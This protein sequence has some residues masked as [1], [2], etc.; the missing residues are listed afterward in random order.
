MDAALKL[1]ALDEEDLKIVSAHAQDAV[2]K[3]A[4]IDYRAGEKRL[5]VAMN[6]FVWEKPDGVF[7]RRN[8][9][10]RSVLHFERVLGVRSTGIDRDNREAVLSLLA[11]RFVPSEAPAGTIELIF[12]GDAAIRLE[13][14]CI[15]ARLADLGAAWDTRSRP[16]HEA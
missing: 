9:R 1:V 4:D 8:E 15:E 2:M 16:A 7:T 10:R 13:V 14:E 6:R 3:L 12:S 11:I 5:L